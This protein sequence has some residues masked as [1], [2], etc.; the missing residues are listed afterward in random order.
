M[1]HRTLIQASRTIL[2]T[3]LL[4]A[5][6]VV[7]LYHYKLHSSTFLHDFAG[8]MSGRF[9]DALQ[10]NNR[11][12]DGVLETQELSL[13][14]HDYAN[15][16]AGWPTILA[17]AISMMVWKGR[18]LILAPAYILAALAASLLGCVVHLTI[19][20]TARSWSGQA[21]HQDWKGVGVGVLSWVL[22][23]LVVLSVDR[24][25]RVSFWPTEDQ[26]ER[27][28]NPLV[29]IWNRL[30]RQMGSPIRRASDPAVGR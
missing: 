10:I 6:I 4:G 16:L 7:S 2:V 24:L 29:R 28:F 30:F 27:E 13:V 14:I 21:W 15:G 11:L 3:V 19:L 22:S 25:L 5:S 18:S 1:N 26:K 23:F 12:V 9:L 17:S 8:Q 20:C